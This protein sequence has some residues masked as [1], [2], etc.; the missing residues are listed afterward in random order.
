MSN[1]IEQK[2][3]ELFEAWHKKE[4]PAVEVRAQNLLGT[5]TRQQVELAWLVFC[6][7]LDSIVIQMPNR[8]EYSSPDSAGA[9]IF[10][11]ASAIESTN[12]GLKVLP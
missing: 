10:D 9:A 2:R 4:F 7:A 1:S 6:A 12:L 11:C 8:F 5:Y 3:R